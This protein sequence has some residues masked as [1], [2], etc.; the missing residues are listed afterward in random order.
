MLP[1]LS[2][3]G[4]FPPVEHALIEPDGL[5]CLGGDLSPSTLVSAYR[6]GIFPWYNTGEP[7]LWW[8]PSE[9]MVLFPDQIH[10]SRSL[11]KFQ[12]QHHIECH[13]NRNFLHV[14]NRC[15]QIKR[16]DQG[17][18]IHPEMISAYQI[19]F[20]QGHAFSVEV[21]I[22][23]KE[24]GGLYGVITPH[25]LCGESMYSTMSNGSKLALVFVCEWLKHHGLK[26]LDCQLH[27]PHLQSMGAHLI[28]R[29]AF[30]RMLSGE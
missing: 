29:K 1:N 14:I 8:S 17:T 24:A 25:V 12:K 2:Q 9:R 22:D 11:S 26:A 30:I 18:W 10:I 4:E 15:A 23:G 5:L 28:K 7:I 19:L 3:L 27:N 21:F 6:Q 16:K 13:W 20:Q